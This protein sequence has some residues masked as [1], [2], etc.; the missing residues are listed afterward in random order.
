MYCSLAGRPG[1][2]LAALEV[3]RREPPELTGLRKDP[4]AIDLRIGICTGEVVVGNIG[5]ENERSYT[6]IGDTV[7]LAAR[8]E[9]ANRIYGTQILLGET[10]AQALG[11]H[12]ETREVDSIAVKGKTESTRIFELLGPAGQVPENLLRLREI[13]SQALL[14]YRAQDWDGAEM[15]FRAC[16]ELRLMMAARSSS[17]A[18]RLCAGRLHAPLDSISPLEE[19]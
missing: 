9:S 15:T 14:A 8:L 11:P 5:S 10:T 17:S 1:E 4:P 13:Y 12:F 18:R 7:N 2:Q 16:L 19:K 3:F 6:V